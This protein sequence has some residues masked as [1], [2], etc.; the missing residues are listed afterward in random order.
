MIQIIARSIYPYSELKTVKYLK[1]NTALAELFKF[2][3]EKIT[4]DAL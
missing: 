4:K 2:D 1:E 3:K